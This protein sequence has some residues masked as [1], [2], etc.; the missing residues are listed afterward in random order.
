MPPVAVAVCR[1]EHYNY[2]VVQ[3]ILFPLIAS[4]VFL[5]GL[6]AFGML[7][8]G[9]RDQRVYWSVFVLL[10]VSLLT[11]GFDSAVLVLGLLGFA[12]EAIVGVSRIHE[13]MATAYIAAVPFFLCSVL[14]ADSRERLAARVVWIL[15]SALFFVFVVTAFVGG[16]LFLSLSADVGEPVV[17]P[18]TSLHGRVSAGPLFALRD[19]A[20]AFVL[21]ASLAIALVAGFRGRIAGPRRL[22]LTGMILGVVI[23][24]GEVYANLTGTYLW[25]FTMI[26][27]SPVVLGSMVFTI[28]ATSAYVLQYSHQSLQL[29][30]ANL[31]LEARSRQLGFMAYHNDM[32]GLPNRSALVR[33]IDALF[34]SAEGSGIAAVAPG[35]GGSRGYTLGEVFLCDLDSFGSVQDSY[36]FTFAEAILR[37][38]GERLEALLGRAGMSGTTVYQVDGDRF[39]LLVRSSLDESRRRL[40]EKQLVDVISSPLSIEGSGE[41][42]LSAG[43]AQCPIT[44]EAKNAETV[45]QRIKLALTETNAVYNTVRRYSPQIHKRLEENRR[46]IQELRRAIRAGEFDVHYQPIVDCTGDVSSGEALVRWSGASPGR[47]IPLAEQSGLIIPI[48]EFVIDHV[49]SDIAALR[50]AYPELVAHINISA[51]HITALDFP[52]IL[53]EHMESHGLAPGCLGVEI[54]ETS[55][56]QESPHVTRTL[57]NIRDAGFSV[58]IDDFGTGHAS[59]SY[60]KQIP[61]ERLKIDASF[62]QG[63]PGSREDRALVDSMIL[64]ANSLGKEVVAEGVETAEQQAYL[65]DRGAAYLQGYLFSRPNTPE[66]FA[67]DMRV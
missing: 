31:Q 43:V 12:R 66:L 9:R 57:G 45:I 60:L 52:R 8:G 4:G 48:T 63:L 41:I 49:C 56:L 21:V 44:E 15:G 33:D 18:Y 24:S 6:L 62:V 25:P 35:A 20:V 16:D 27:V 64:L 29:H 3:E 11:V 61:A 13:L 37:A 28:A 17:T 23:G 50:A 55:F 5:A 47:F 36:G 53:L 34:A 19:G 39:A 40:L 67:K 7:A 51:R 26:P 46:L 22:I 38:V 65:V 14:P 32:T 30:K 1:R 59:L 58:S 54:T 42:Y 10:A 2:D